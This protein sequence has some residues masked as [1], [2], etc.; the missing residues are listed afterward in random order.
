MTAR[1][2]TITSDLPADERTA[3]LE[4][5]TWRLFVWLHF[6]ADAHGDIDA[7]ALQIAGVRTRHARALGDLLGE[8][9]AARLLCWDARGGRQLLHL[10]AVS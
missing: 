6:L 3:R 1:A 7:I 4:H 5:D 8:L 10:V 2:R 9:A